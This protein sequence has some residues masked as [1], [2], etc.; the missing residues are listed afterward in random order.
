MKCTMWYYFRMGCKRLFY[1]KALYEL[2][3][4]QSGKIYNMNI[5][6]QQE[7]YGCLW[8]FTLRTLSPINDTILFPTSSDIVRLLCDFSFHATQPCFKLHCQ[9]T[10]NI[11]SQ[12]HIL[13]E[14]HLTFMQHCTDLQRKSNLTSYL[15]TSK[16]SAGGKHGRC[17]PH[18]KGFSRT[19]CPTNHL[20]P[21][22][23]FKQTGHSPKPE[24][25]CKPQLGHCALLLTHQI[26]LC[27]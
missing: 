8:L 4:F 25:I 13:F 19:H 21:T 2:P 12:F 1:T 10:Y 20:Q 11:A 17:T 22:K 6:Y 15:S 5:L 16:W 3:P 9:S 26:V 27:Y 18:E 24:T 23:H 7:S 14:A